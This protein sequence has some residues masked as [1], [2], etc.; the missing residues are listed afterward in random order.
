MRPGAVTAGSSSGFPD[1][2]VITSLPAWSNERSILFNPPPL[3][4]EV[5]VA[6]TPCF[7]S[8]EYFV[9]QVLFTLPSFR[10][11]LSVAI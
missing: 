3:T 9:N 2:W 8:I 7:V 11:S 10:Q 1:N 5:E 4:K 6:Q